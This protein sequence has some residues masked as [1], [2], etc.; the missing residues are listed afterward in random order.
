MLAPLVEEV[1]PIDMSAIT[2]GCIK[3]LL[4]KRPSNSSPGEDCISYHHLKKM[5]SIHH[6][7]ATLFSKILLKDTKAP[8]EWCSAKIILIHKGED[9][10][11]P[12]NFRPIVLTSA[13]GRLFNKL[14]AIRLEHYLRKERPS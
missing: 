9:K 11:T 8:K 13:I 12:E 7:L 6:F 10:S 14:I 3:R 1:T 2:P 5:P 4:K